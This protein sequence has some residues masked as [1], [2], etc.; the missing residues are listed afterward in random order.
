MEDRQTIELTNVSKISIADRLI[1][2]K[3]D[4]GL[5]L[6][7]ERINYFQLTDNVLKIHSDRLSFSATVDMKI[8]T[9]RQL[10]PPYFYRLPISETSII[11]YNARKISS[12]V[13]DNGQNVATVS[14][15]D[16]QSL[17]FTVGADDRDK[18]FTNLAEHHEHVVRSC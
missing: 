7:T 12:I 3:G 11:C 2:V 5:Q 15:S 4:N 16:G 18:I 10:L 13:F 17:R 1:H 8:E 6:S 14:F 9:L